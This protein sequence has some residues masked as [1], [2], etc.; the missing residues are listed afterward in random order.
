MKQYFAETMQVNSFKNDVYLLARTK[1]EKRYPHFKK[2][3]FFYDIKY[4]TET[5][6]IYV[7]CLFEDVTDYRDLRGI[8]FK[9]FVSIGLFVFA[10][11]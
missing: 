2:S 11:Q 5:L 10:T 3:H 6:S 8:N 9:S 4:S 7:F 1:I